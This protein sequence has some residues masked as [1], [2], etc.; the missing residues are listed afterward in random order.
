MRNIRIL[1]VLLAVVTVATVAY[2]SQNGTQNI[3]NANTQVVLGSQVPL[4]EAMALNQPIC[5]LVVNSEEVVLPAEFKTPRYLP[6]GYSMQDWWSVNGMVSIYYAPGPVCGENA[7]YTTLESGVIHYIAAKEISPKSEEIQK[8]KKYF[9]EYK[10]YSQRGNLISLFN[11]KGWPAMGWESGMKESIT[12]EAD[13]TVIDVRPV[14]YAAQIQT[15]DPAEKSF[16]M[17]KAY[18]PLAELK[19]IAESIG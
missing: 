15:I 18:L 8:G 17:V 10:S 9:E 13:G 2:Y 7:K 16:Y 11:V 14:P 12:M 1:S 6:L 3:G 5:S 19:K 4:P